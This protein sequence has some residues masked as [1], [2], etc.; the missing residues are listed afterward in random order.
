MLKC[1]VPAMAADSRLLIAECLLPTDPRDDVGGLMGFQDMSML[2][3]GGKE[4][5]EEGFR[6]IVEE[7]GL[8]IEK[9]WGGDGVGRF[10]VI[11]CRLA[12]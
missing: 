9:I 2:C 1:V 12:D 6:K 8:A 10:G 11:E 7:A 4:R 5:T 3:I